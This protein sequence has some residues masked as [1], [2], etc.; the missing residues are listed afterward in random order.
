MLKL[1]V[2]MCWYIAYSMYIC[3]YI[4]LNHFYHLRMLPTVPRANDSSTH[5]FI[6][7]IRAL[8]FFF[9]FDFS[10]GDHAI[11]DN[12]YHPL[13]SPRHKVVLLLPL[14]RC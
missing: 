1:P 10:R 2:K 6:P 5:L 11:I 3:L 8:F 13:H 9:F 4:L 14:M 12:S 7:S